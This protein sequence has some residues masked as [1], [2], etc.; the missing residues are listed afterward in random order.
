[1]LSGEN[2]DDAPDAAGPSS[3]AASAARIVGGCHG[4]GSK[5]ANIFSSSFTVETVDATRKK[6]YV[7]RFR[8]NMSVVDPPASSR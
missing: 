3:S 2:F 7:Q 4:I 6:R 1:M 5:A 8:D